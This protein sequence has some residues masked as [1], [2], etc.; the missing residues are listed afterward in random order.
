M[1]LNAQ[2]KQM[3]M[4][5]RKTNKRHN[6]ARVVAVQAQGPLHRQVVPTGHSRLSRHIP[7]LGALQDA[8]E[9]NVAADLHYGGVV[10]PSMGSWCKATLKT[11][12]TMWKIRQHLRSWMMQLP[13]RIA[14]A[15]CLPGLQFRA[16]RLT[17]QSWWRQ[18][19]LWLKQR[20]L[21]IA[22]MNTRYYCGVQLGSHVQVLWVRYGC[23]LE[24]QIL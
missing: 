24:A 16:R 20:P 21:S 17:L 13:E 5:N 12:G 11:V 1:E 14:M 9:V 18:G 15:V 19:Q 4:K 2:D 23:G 3:E 10:E 7:L 8:L 22:Y 6:H